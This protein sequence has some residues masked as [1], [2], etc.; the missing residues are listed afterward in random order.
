MKSVTGIDE[1]E[2]SSLTIYPNPVS[3]QATLTY[4][5]PSSN[6]V[7]ITILN[8]LG[9]QVKTLMSSPDLKAGTYHITIDASSFNPGIYYC[10]LNV[11]NQKA[12]VKKLIIS[13]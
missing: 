2:Q 11:N 7:S 13:K 3:G 5:I 9:Q 6:E 12:V 8:L 4:S 1:I 10:K